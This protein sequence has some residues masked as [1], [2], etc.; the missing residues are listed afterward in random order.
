MD[1]LKSSKGRSRLALVLVS[2]TW[3]VATA[4][5][6]LA[7][8][9]TEPSFPHRVHVVDN[10]L[11]CTFCHGA[12][13]SADEPGMPP[14]ELCAPCHDRFDGDKPPER[15]VGAFYS[16]RSRYRTVAVS[17]RT[18]EVRFS[19]RSHVTTAKLE[20]ARCHGDVAQQEG[21]PLDPLASKSSC[22]DCHARHGMANACSDC[23]TTIDAAWRPP[24][25]AAG[26]LRAHG[27]CA[28]GTRERSV[29]RC[30]LCHQEGASCSACHHQ[31]APEDHD[32]TFRVRT[33]GLQA[34][35][36]RSR[37]A[38][39]HTQDSCQQCHEMTR[40]RSHRGGFGFTQQRHCV[41]CH[42][43]LGDTGCAVCHPA[44]PSHDLATPLPADH[45]PAM[46]CR[47]CHGNGT[48]LPHPD[49]G[50]SCTACHR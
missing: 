26:W 21:V 29:D 42:L 46:N 36:D 15:R 20:C 39:C 31:M 43:P 23:H 33:H 5:W 40:P 24:T 22:M 44:A 6:S 11:A 32:Q 49:G 2:S 12:V 38:L 28:M 16:E 27:V 10:D 18:A 30:E 37:C 19:H 48:A 25:H 17:G 4:C 41:G 1:V 8:G 45:T 14:P 50:H 3:L 9:R 34:S 13:R 47:A 7:G 35:I